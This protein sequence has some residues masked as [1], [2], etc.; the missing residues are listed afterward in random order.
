MRAQLHVVCVTM[1]G[2]DSL[3][4]VDEVYKTVYL[5]ERAEVY[6][7][8]EVCREVMLRGRT[9]Q[10]RTRSV[11]SVPSLCLLYALR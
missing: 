7:G 6:K 5:Y 4:P 9:G 11:C 10:V 8:R 2:V 3:H 1:I